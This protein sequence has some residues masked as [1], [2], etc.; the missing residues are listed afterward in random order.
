MRGIRRMDL[1]APVLAWARSLLTCRRT[2]GDMT[3]SRQRLSTGIVGLDEVLG[4][5]LIRGGIYLVMGKPGAGKT[6]CG[7][8]I[9]FAHAARKERAAYVTLLAET[10]SRMTLNL[11]RMRFFSQAPIGESL[12]YLGGY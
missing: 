7:N 1:E 11:E 10:H 12:L 6:I 4:G 5:G 8:Q 2:E 3:D 9:C